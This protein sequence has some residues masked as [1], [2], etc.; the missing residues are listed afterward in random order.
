MTD[1]QGPAGRLDAIEMGTGDRVVVLSHGADSSKEAFFPLLPA[2][3]QAGYLAIAYDAR[4][5]GSSEGQPDIDTRGDD[6]AAVVAAV[7]DS[8]ATS[9]VLGGS[10]L[11]GAVSLSAA[12]DLDADGLIL[13]APAVPDA[14]AIDV[15]NIPTLIAVA[16]DNEP[17][18]TYARD[19]ADVLGVQPIIVSGSAHGARMLVGHPELSEQIASFVRAVP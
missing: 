9:V 13:L 4:G 19:L 16:E 3:A 2:L 12:K 8:G 15:P 1:F 5:I 10:S 7:R 11:G 6:L 18:T 14:S 17:F